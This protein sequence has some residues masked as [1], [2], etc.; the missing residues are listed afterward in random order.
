MTISII[1]PIYNM[2]HLMRRCI[3]SLL[4]QT[5]EDFELLLID[6]GSTDGSP[7]ICDE[8]EKKDS[9]IRVFHK[10]NG[11]LSDARNF[12]LSHAIGKYTIFADP[13]DWVSPDGLD[14]LYQK[15]EKEQADMTI[16]DLYREDKY[17]RHYM[18]Q[19]PSA[20]DP[21]TV[22]KELFYRLGGFTVNKLIRRD[23]YQRFDISYPKGIYGC[24][25]QYTMVCILQFPIKIAYL[26]VAFYHYMYN[27]NSLTR[28]YDER[29]YKMDVHICEMFTTL[30]QGTDALETARKNKT[31][32][33]FMRAF[34]NGGSYYSSKM[35][36]QRF[37]SY[38]P[39]VFQLHEQFIVKCCM[40]LAC[41][42]CYRPAN[43]FVFGLFRLKQVLKRAKAKLNLMLICF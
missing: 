36:Q 35:F 23:V 38:R 10:Q 32:A 12:G 40:Y 15:A 5:F 27:S 14:L 6:D 7:A 42:G 41:L 3:D 8:Y 2:A 9:R 11:G 1:V 28:F 34:W 16:C 24:E 39:M 30:L 26:P 13:D 33:I 22:Q 37:S 21:S 4:S 17:N 18:C 20:L 25:D 31:E 19:Q 43:H 29:T